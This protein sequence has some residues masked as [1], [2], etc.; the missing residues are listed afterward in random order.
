MEIKFIAKRCL[1]FKEELS[2]EIPTILLTGQT[3]YLKIGR[4]NLLSDVIV[5]E[6]DEIDLTI[7][8]IKL[9]KPTLNID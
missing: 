7:K 3:E 8:N 1:S 5:I 4:I 6:I 9:L 2:F